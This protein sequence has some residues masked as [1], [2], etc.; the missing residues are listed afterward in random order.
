MKGVSKI[1]ITILKTYVPR[2]KVK[3]TVLKSKGLGLKIIHAKRLKIV[4]S[5][6]E[7]VIVDKLLRS[8]KNFLLVYLDILS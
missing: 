6:R 8:H 2:I 1:A 3:N 7:D 5:K 4:L